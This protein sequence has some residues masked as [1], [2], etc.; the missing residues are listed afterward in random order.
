MLKYDRTVLV[1]INLLINSRLLLD[2]L[3]TKA[4]MSAGQYLGWCFLMHH[5][6]SRTNLLSPR[7]CTQAY[8]ASLR[9]RIT[10]KPIPRSR[11]FL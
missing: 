11:E 6:H 3:P 1:G 10:N 2:T 4:L 7:L 9:T 5:E 8:T